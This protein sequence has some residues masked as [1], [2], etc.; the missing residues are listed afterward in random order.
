M[1][2]E[3]ERSMESARISGIKT[4]RNLL[5][6]LVSLRMAAIYGVFAQICLHQFIKDCAV[7]KADP[8]GLKTKLPEGMVTFTQFMNHLALMGNQAQV[9][10]K[11][12]ANR[13]LTR[14]Y[15]KEVFRIT[16]SFCKDTGQKDALESE[17]WYQF[18]RVLVNS[19][20]HDH[21]LRFSNHDKKI[22][23]VTYQGITI[24]VTSENKPL[25]APLEILLNLSEDIIAF[26]QNK[27]S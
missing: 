4:Q 22:L 21:L 14:N 27:L 2:E 16:Q 20:S 9:E 7:Q 13:A 23:P 8:E 15:L 19:L 12:N 26:A 18:V 10:T 17:P 24:D 25:S 5:K 1:S 6:H 11:R 3:T